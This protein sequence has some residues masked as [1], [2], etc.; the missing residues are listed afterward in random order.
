M[1]ILEKL[2]NGI[3]GLQMLF[4]CLRQKTGG[5]EFACFMCYSSV[6]TAQ[7]CS[8]GRLDVLSSSQVSL[9]GVPSTCQ[10]SSP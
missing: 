6:A 5:G 10:S 2:V 8:L 1:G 7:I 9:M 4:V 3:V